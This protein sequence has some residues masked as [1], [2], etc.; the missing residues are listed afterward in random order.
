[1]LVVG[2]SQNPPTLSHL[3][4]PAAHN[5]LHIRR[6]WCPHLSCSNPQQSLPSP[7]TPS[8]PPLSLS[9]VTQ[10]LQE[11]LRHL[12]KDSD[13]MSPPGLVPLSSHPRSCYPTPSSCSPTRV[14]PSSCPEEIQRAG[15]LRDGW[16]RKRM[17]GNVPGRLPLEKPPW[18]VGG[19]RSFSRASGPAETGGVPGCRTWSFH[20]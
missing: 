2:S 14:V 4:F 1:M 10:F 19:H 18:V 7:G 17:W 12:C 8:P 16:G 9:R 20:P 11:R 13:S 3:V 5:S 6:G 15:E